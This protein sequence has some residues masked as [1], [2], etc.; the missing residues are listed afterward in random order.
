MRRTRLRGPARLETAR[1]VLRPPVPGDA[2]A[3]SGAI[4]NYDVARW[5]GQ[6][7]YP[8]GPEDA[9]RFIA[10]AG[11]RTW[12]IER[13]GRLIGGVSAEDELGYWLS[14]DVWGQGLATEACDAA[15]DAFFTQTRRDSLPS[16]H[17]VG[18]D[19]SAR[20]LVK[21]GFRHAGEQRAD[22]RA[23]SQVMA[24]RLMTLTR[25]EW[26]ARRR[27]ALRTPRLTLRELRDGDLPALIRIAGQDAVARMLFNITVPWPEADARRWL[28]AWRYRG[29]LGFRA[30]I[31]RRGR[32]IGTIGI[33]RLP[34]RST[35]TCMYF[36]DPS[37]W[38]HGYAKEALVHFLYD[39]MA[40]FHVQTLWA[41]HFDDNPASGAVL[42]HAGFMPHHPDTGTSAARPGEHPVTVYRLNRADLR[43]LAP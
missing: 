31:C 16:A 10:G 6:V 22:A 1:L 8:Y 24:T 34:G 11:A 42:R 5:L 20:V 12:M 13:D 27:Y 17:I 26:L 9:D 25:A 18:N 32:M 15:V 21:Q 4:G 30:A 41:D 43:P 2:A 33:A 23:L 40:R 28:N 14:R 19:R 36:L 37:H 38:G 29:R 7:P 39:T 3:L 35:V